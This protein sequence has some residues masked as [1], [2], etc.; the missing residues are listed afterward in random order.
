MGIQNRDYYRNEATGG[1][2]SSLQGWSMC[3]TL[4]IVTIA[5]YVLQFLITVRPQITVAEMMRHADPEE[6]AV[7]QKM[8]DSGKG[9]DLEEIAA[10]YGD[11]RYISL[12]EEWGALDPVK[13]SR[14]Q[15]WRLLTYAF[16]HS[17]DSQL[18]IIFNM[19]ALWMFGSAIEQLLRGREFL[20]FYLISAI[21]SGIV[22]VLYGFA[23]HDPTGAIG[24][25]G[26]VMAVSTL[27]AIYYPTAP[28]TIYFLFT[29]EARWLIILYAVWDT[30][31]VLKALSGMPSRD[32]VAHAAHLGGLAFGF[33]YYKFRWRLSDWFPTRG[34]Q[35]IGQR[36]TKWWT[37]PPLRVYQ[38]PPVERERPV[39]KAKPVVSARDMELRVDEILK[40]IKEQGEP[41]LTEEER[42]LLRDA[43]QAYK[44]RNS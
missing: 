25:S 16:L 17:R 20:A 21:A 13:V 28:I 9:R 12:L 22:N 39:V 36:L 43:S 41:S 7:M 40:K 42:N 10:N 15:V 44:K 2:L 26:A 35:S 24:A 32:Q 33:L 14:G 34:G 30:M 4:V 3:Q 11:G 31:P 38:S 23:I 37:R 8:I 6:R 29:I 19:L 1:A 5:V 27:F 18:H